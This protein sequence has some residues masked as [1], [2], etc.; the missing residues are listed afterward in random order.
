VGPSRR[1][2]ECAARVPAVR[3]ELVGGFFGLHGKDELRDCQAHL[4]LLFALP[5]EVE[6]EAGLDLGRDRF[7]SLA[8]V[9]ELGIPAVR[10]QRLRVARQDGDALHGRLDF[11]E[12]WPVGF[13]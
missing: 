1:R 3:A 13:S 11:L 7:L 2:A 5:A 10:H 9:V 4:L 8:L 6:I 12:V